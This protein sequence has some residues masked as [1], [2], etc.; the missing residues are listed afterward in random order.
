MALPLGVGVLLAARIE[1][2]TRALGPIVQGMPGPM[3]RVLALGV[4]GVLGEA[5]MSGWLAGVSHATGVDFRRAGQFIGTSAGS[6]VAAELAAGRSPRD[7]VGSGLPAEEE[8]PRGAPGAVRAAIERANRLSAGVLWPFAA[9]ALAA[10]APGGA[11][12]RAALLRGLPA[13]TIALDDLRARIAALGARF[14]GRLRIVALD[15]ASGRRT[16]FG[17]PGAPP[18]SVAEAVA[19]SCAIPTV[20][21]PVQIGGRDYVDGGVWSPTN[22]DLASAGRGERVLCLVPSGSLGGS[23]AAPLRAVTTG[24]RLATE[25]EAAGVRRRGAVVEIVTPDARAAAAMGTGLMD[26]RPRAS[27]LAEGFRQGSAAALATAGAGR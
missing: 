27:V 22:L 13:G 14:D 1:V 6:I 12:A 2:G 5:W 16:V 18:A 21:R 20:M 17:A 23:V 7:P 26:P 3:P 19:A 15:R 11:L 9:T 25:L 8:G 24:W 4:G 10:A